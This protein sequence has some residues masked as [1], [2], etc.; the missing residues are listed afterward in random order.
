MNSYSNLTLFIGIKSISSSFIKNNRTKLITN[1][2]S[3]LI[4]PIWFNQWIVYLYQNYSID[5]FYFNFY[6]IEDEET[7]SISIGNLLD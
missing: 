3:S 6:S 7:Y 4:K 2:S 5:Q 1:H